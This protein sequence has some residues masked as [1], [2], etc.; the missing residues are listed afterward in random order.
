MTA[1]SIPLSFLIGVQPSVLGA[2]GNPLGLFGVLET[3]DPSIPIG[4]A[5]GFGGL[6][7]VQ[8]WFGVN[9]PEAALAAIYFKGYSNGT[10]LPGLVWFMQYNTAAVGGYV[11]G[12]SLAGLTLTQLQALSGTLITTTDGVAS[13]SLAINLSSATSFSNAATLIQTGVQGGTPSSTATVTY[14]AL[15]HGFVIHSPTTGPSSTEA[16]VSG[17]L[18]AGLK[19]TQATGAVISA[20][21]AIQTPVGAVAAL[22]AATQNWCTLS[23]VWEPSDDDKVALA[24]AVSAQ[25]ENYAYVGWD[26]TATPTD[27][28]SFAARTSTLDGRVAIWGLDTGDLY[29][30]SNNG[31]TQFLPMPANAGAVAKAVFFMGATASINFQETNGRLDYAFQSQA[32]LIPDVYDR[33]LAGQLE[34][35]GYNYYGFFASGATQAQNFQRGQISGQ[36]KWADAYVDQIQMSSD[37]QI[38]LLQ[39]RQKVKALPYAQRGYNGMRAALMDPI[40]KHVNFGSIVAGVNISA[41]QRQE[42]NTEAG[43]NIADTLQAQGW[44][45]FIGDAA[46][47]VR[48]ERGSPPSKFWYTDGGSIQ[49]INLAAIDVQ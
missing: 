28:A 5:A 49:R 15:R 25:G 10:L 35:V 6:Q 2:G 26:T 33:T 3:Q 23:T 42:V 9:S 8:D 46:P 37:F 16:F 38:A 17:T 47:D 44:Y 12:G 48:G 24:T 31:V 11:R 22:V 34:T 18:A 29:P 27:P 4:V 19:L 41:A 32:G 14:D 7:E 45:L 36:W 21:A 20:G 39:F 40:K 43:F 30:V 13:T 1:Q